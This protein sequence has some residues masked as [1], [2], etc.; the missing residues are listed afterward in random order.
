[1]ASIASGADSSGK[2]SPL[3]ETRGCTE[4]A[5]FADAAASAA[6]DADGF[7]DEP[8]QFRLHPRHRFLHR[9]AE[10][11]RPLEQQPGDAGLFVPGK[12]V[13]P[14]ELGYGPTERVLVGPDDLAARRG[15][16][17]RPRGDGGVPGSEKSGA[18]LSTT[19]VSPAATP[20]SSTRKVRLEVPPVSGDTPRTS[21]TGR[22]SVTRRA[23]RSRS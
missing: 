20:A 23:T 18:T 22:Q 21:A 15:A 4:I 11:H 19:G 10:L 5:P 3:T 14:A 13:E 8:G 1:M 16:R 7:L 12:R 9:P 6:Y 17:D 2:Q